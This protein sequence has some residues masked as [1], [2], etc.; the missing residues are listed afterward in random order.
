MHAACNGLKTALLRASVHGESAPLQCFELCPLSLPLHNPSLPLCCLTKL[1][2]Q[3]PHPALQQ[4]SRSCPC[5][6]VTTAPTRTAGRVPVHPKLDKS[7]DVMKAL[8]DTGTEQLGAVNNVWLPAR[9]S[10]GGAISRNI[11]CPG[12]DREGPASHCVRCALCAVAQRPI[13][14]T[15][16]SAG[17]AQ[18]RRG[19]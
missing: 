2:P 15:A 7:R 10:H 17:L 12:P 3:A 11:V 14:C 6:S 18:A 19:S 16:G 4:T 9:R 13:P 5:C 1:C 8:S